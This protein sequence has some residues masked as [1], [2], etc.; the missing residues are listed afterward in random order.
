MTRKKARVKAAKLFRKISGCSFMD[1]HKFI[2][3][4][5][6]GVSY[7][8]VNGTFWVKTYTPCECGLGGCERV[9]GLTYGDRKFTMDDLDP[10]YAMWDKFR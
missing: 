9:S 5:R 10:L 7:G 3:Q 8:D 1:A 2:C 4:L 6:T